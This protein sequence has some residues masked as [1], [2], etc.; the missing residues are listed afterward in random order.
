VRI[1]SIGRLLFVADVGYGSREQSDLLLLSPLPFSFL[2]PVIQVQ[3]HH[4]DNSK[5]LCRITFLQHFDRLP[6][7]PSSP[8][9][10]QV[11]VHDTILR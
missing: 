5:Q 7:T 10:F 2:V 9:I 11:D 3:G 8:L 4:G 1:E 6:I